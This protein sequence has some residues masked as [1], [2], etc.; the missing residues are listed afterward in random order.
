MSDP[1]SWQQLTRMITGYWP[2]RAIYVAAKLRIADHLKDGPR[3]AADLAA[4]AGVAAV[5]LYR[6]LRALAGA[7]VFAQGPGERFRLNP[8][9]EP[10]RD[11]GPESRPPEELDLRYEG[12]KRHVPPPAG[13]ILGVPAGS[14]VRMRSSGSQD[15]LHICLEPGLLSRVAAEAFGLDPA[16]VSLP[17]LDGLDLPPLRAAM[18]AVNDELTAG[19]AGGPLA[20]GSLANVLAVHLLRRAQP[21]DAEN[22]EVRIDDALDRSRQ[23]QRRP[24]RHRGEGGGRSARGR[25]PRGAVAG[26]LP[27]WTLRLPA[28]SSPASGSSWAGRDSRSSPRRPSSTRRNKGF[29][30]GQ[31]P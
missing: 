24:H 29:V 7:G 19:G 5:P 22:P 30:R 28:R 6:L 26:H 12:V 15:Q 13:S 4:A 10:L 16:R 8:L 14:A 1:Q 20:A 25:T 3:T 31:Q 2:S 18:L 11:G 17:P 9:A 23:H 27:A 21:F